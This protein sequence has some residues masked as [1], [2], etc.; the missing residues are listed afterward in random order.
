MWPNGSS[1]C[2]IKPKSPPP[3]VLLIKDTLQLDIVLDKAV[4]LR[5]LVRGEANSGKPSYQS[6]CFLLCTIALGDCYRGKFHDSFFYIFGQKVALV[7]GFSSQS[8][9][10]HPYAYDWDVGHVNPELPISSPM[11]NYWSPTPIEKMT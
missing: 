6:H 10:K 3:T 9:S 2:R 8:S 1:L 4:A 5:I 11:S 7:V